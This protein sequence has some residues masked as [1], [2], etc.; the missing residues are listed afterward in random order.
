MKKESQLLD[1]I[2]TM[3]AMV[4]DV[5]PERIRTDVHVQDLGFTSVTLVE[6]VDLLSAALGDELHPGLFFEYTTLEQLESYLLAEKPDVVAKCLAS[7]RPE[8]NSV[9]PRTIEFPRMATR[10]G[11]RLKKSSC[12]RMVRQ[13]LYRIPL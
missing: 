4:L 13:I 1:R 11:Q 3:T 2:V 6:I 5:N 12:G 10:G 7:K 8:Q 9:E